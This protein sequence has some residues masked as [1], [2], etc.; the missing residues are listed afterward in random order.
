MMWSL[1]IVMDISPISTS[2][3]VWCNGSALLFT[4]SLHSSPPRQP[5]TRAPSSPSS[6]WTLV[7]PYHSCVHFSSYNN[8][9]NT[10]LMCVEWREWWCGWLMCSKRASLGDEKKHG[11]SCMAQSHTRPVIGKAMCL[12]MHVVFV[13]IFHFSSTTTVLCDD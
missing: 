12:G 5:A 2:F 9:T 1:P 11:R 13:I 10:L 3:P 7:S 4:P 8:R 6:C